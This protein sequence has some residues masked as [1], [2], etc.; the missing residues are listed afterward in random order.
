M[1]NAADLDLFDPAPPAG[2]FQVAYFGAMGEANDL[3]AVVEAARLVPDVRFVLMG[4]GKRRRRA[5]AH[6]AAERALPKRQQD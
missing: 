3:T 4:D 5:R 2:P 1:P 6:R